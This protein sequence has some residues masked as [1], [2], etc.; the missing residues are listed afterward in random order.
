MASKNDQSVKN[1][2]SSEAGIGVPAAEVDVEAEASYV[3]PLLNLLGLVAVLIVIAIIRFAPERKYWAS[4]IE[5]KTASRVV[6]SRVESSPESESPA[7]EETDE[8]DASV[9]APRPAPR[10]RERRA[11]PLDRKAI[12]AAKDAVEAAK[13]DRVAAEERLKEAEARLKSAAVEAARQTLA[14]KTLSYR[15]R[16]YR[17]RLS[18]AVAK[19]NRIKVER[20]KLQKDVKMLG[21]APRAKPKPLLTKSPVAKPADSDEFFFE[22]RQNRVS[23]INLERL[24]EKAGVDFRKRMTLGENDPV[25]I[26]KAG[27][28]GV[29]SIKVTMAR[30]ASLAVNDMRINQK[31]GYIFQ[32]WEVVPEFNERGETFETTRNPISEYSLALRPLDPAKTTITLWIYPDSFTLYRKLRDDL[33]AR[34]FTVAARPMPEGMP[35]RASISG[36]L[37]AGQ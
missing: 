34:G 12:A 10:V 13:V 1:D 37:S 29:F 17:T 23:Y 15:I 7:V 36:T 28:I 35:I 6:A 21:L 25:M 9:P 32:S 33:H 11:K 4:L 26:V 31:G 5:K 18:V 3:K 2:R 14:A 27:P 22:V 30:L 20:T 19:G 24:L 16:D 8:E